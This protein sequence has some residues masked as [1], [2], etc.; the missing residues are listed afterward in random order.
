MNYFDNTIKKIKVCTGLG[1][2]SW[3]SG[4]VLSLLWKITGRSPGAENIQVCP[5]PCMKKCSGGV[6]VKMSPTGE[7]LKWREPEEALE[8]FAHQDPSIKE[9]ISLRDAIP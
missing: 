5:V 9:G 2:K 6:T 7:L 4:K 3:Q 1:C 8:V